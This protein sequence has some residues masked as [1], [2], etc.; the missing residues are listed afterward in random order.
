M[1]YN[2]IFRKKVILWKY[3][4]N[5]CNN[6]N[7]LYLVKIKIIIIY[8]KNNKRQSIN[9]TFVSLKKNFIIINNYQQTS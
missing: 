9:F 4:F 8:L 1:F 5:E 2:H 7:Q 3:Y 6:K